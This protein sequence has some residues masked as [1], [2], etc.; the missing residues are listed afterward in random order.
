MLLHDDCKNQVAN[1]TV[2]LLKTIYRSYFAF[3]KTVL[4]PKSCIRESYRRFDEVQIIEEML[5]E[6]SSFSLS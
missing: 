4:K 3:Y 2:K 6:M 1:G 5:E